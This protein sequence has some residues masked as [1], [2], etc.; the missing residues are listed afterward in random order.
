MK[1]P[2]P[3]TGWAD[4]GSFALGV[5][6]EALAHLRARPVRLRAVPTPATPVSSAG[7]G[8]L[9]PPSASPLRAPA[10]PRRSGPRAPRPAG[11]GPRRSRP[12]PDG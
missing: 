4:V 11:P 1:Q 12:R 6:T 3:A 7:G 5:L 10:R 8:P 2:P 9:D